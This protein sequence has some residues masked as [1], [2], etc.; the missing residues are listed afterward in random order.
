MK[1]D[2]GKWLVSKDKSSGT[3]LKCTREKFSDYLRDLYGPVQ[4]SKIFSQFR[5]A[6][7]EEHCRLELM[8]D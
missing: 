6:T 7:F 4:A 8:E 1:S 2:Y 3:A 5:R